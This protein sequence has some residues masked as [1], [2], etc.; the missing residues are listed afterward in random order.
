M[1]LSNVTAIQWEA[2]AVA[3]AVALPE[4]VVS[5]Y[6]R[7]G[8]SVPAAAAAARATVRRMPH[9][10]RHIPSA[11]NLFV[12]PQTLLTMGAQQLSLWAP[13]GIVEALRFLSPPFA[14]ACGGVVAGYGLRSLEAACG[15]LGRDGPSALGFY[16]PQLVQ[17]LRCDS[18]EEQG[19]EGEAMGRL[20]QFLRSVCRRDEAFAHQLLWALRGE[21]DDNS[22]S[23]KPSNRPT[24][25]ARGRGSFFGS[26]SPTTDAA[27]AGMKL[28]PSSVPTFAD[29]CAALAMAVVADFS[30]EALA[31]YT[32]QFEYVGALV[33]V[34]RQLAEEKG[35]Q[36]KASRQAR[37]SETISG[38]GRG[39]G[40]GSYELFHRPLF[41]PTEDASN[42]YLAQL[43]SAHS[44]RS[45][46]SNAFGGLG[47]AAH[48]PPHSEQ[49]IPGGGEWDEVMA[50]NTPIYLPT[51]PT[52]R[53]VAISPSSNAAIV[54]GQSSADVSSATAVTKCPI[55]IQF[56]CVPRDRRSTAT[57]L[58]RPMDDADAEA[59][60]SSGGT[61]APHRSS[62]STDW[63]HRSPSEATDSSR[64]GE[65]GNYRHH[66]HEEGGYDGGEGHHSQYHA[67]PVPRRVIFRAG[68][69]VRQDQLATQLI[70][71]LRRAFEAARVP[72]FLF[73]Y[74]VVPTAPGCGVLEAPPLGAQSRNALGAVVDAGLVGWFTR[75]YG[76]PQS[77]AFR[78]ARQCFIESAASYAVAS[79]LL[80][81]KD[82]HNDNI[83]LDPA[84][85][86]IHVGFGGFLLDGASDG[87]D[88]SVEA[89]PFK[90][91]EE[92][93]RLM[94]D[95]T[96]AEGKQRRKQQRLRA[97][98]SSSAAT[99]GNGP[100]LNA[101]AQFGAAEP[102]AGDFECPEAY[103]HFVATTV[104]CFLAARRYARQLCILVELM[105]DSGLPCLRP[106]RTVADLAARLGVGLGDHEAAAFM[107]DR[108][109]ESRNNMRTTLYDRYHNMR[110]GIEM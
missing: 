8:S 58:R 86:L 104:R 13:C 59:D 48:H 34:S 12:T 33:D 96:T 91:T 3:G 101:A 38:S 5:I 54:V 62:S 44:T 11:V 61:A 97:A 2:Y 64:E 94:G 80:N 55:L 73:P 79:F 49:C 100:T 98:A 30:E 19:E 103:E 60:L 6:D 7:F 10:F 105:L 75:Q 4:A 93:L 109:K 36:D 9:L 1:F 32:N 85:H 102:S 27:A 63:D 71:V 70:S 108:I 66:H 45:A 53:I 90:L 56:L 99:N 17:C 21:G 89:A 29:R 107:R 31:S 40:V 26:T 23:D 92:M 16:M 78:T 72:F 18:G 68:D 39:G 110:G 25:T 46:N 88:L 43:A 15:A 42:P 35:P 87:G 14:N 22:R 74:R 41:M 67:A 81:A 57:K 51:D 65:E 24:A 52:M 106:A 77:P 20:A 82:R 83:L 76:D 28:P 47:A 69:D 50:R 84:G 95:C 37:L